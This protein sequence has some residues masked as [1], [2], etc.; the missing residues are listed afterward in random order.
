MNRNA[1]TVKVQ[2]KE[3]ENRD[4]KQH[5]ISFPQKY[6]SIYNL[7]TTKKIKTTWW[8]CLLAAVINFS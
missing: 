1:A 2:E 3:S 6:I 5:H 4:K 8:L 7:E